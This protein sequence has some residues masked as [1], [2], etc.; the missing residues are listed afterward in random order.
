MT[1][2]KHNFLTLRIIA[3]FKAGALLL[4][5]LLLLDGYIGYKGMYKEYYTY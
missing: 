2:Y 3:D 5:W 4:F 1:F